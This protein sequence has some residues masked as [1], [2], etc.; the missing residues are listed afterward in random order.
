MKE[1]KIKKEHI[2]LLNRAYV[3][4]EDGEFGAPAIDC[5]RPYGNSSVVEDII[6]I[7][8]PKIPAKVK[9]LLD[10]GSIDLE[11]AFTSKEIE[12]FEKLHQET[13]FVLQIIL[14]NVNKSP[15]SLIGKTFVIND[16]YQWVEK[17]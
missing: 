10:D 11:Q 5:K 3:R 9:E 1:I 6:E 17:K 13:E 7:I 8:K 4:W 2:A 16:S 15:K 12:Q 14:R